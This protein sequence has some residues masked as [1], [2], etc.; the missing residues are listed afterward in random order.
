[1]N[2]VAGIQKEMKQNNIVSTYANELLLVGI[3]Y[4]TNE[5]ITG[6]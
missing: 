6:T 1:L 5:N 2:G 4:F 3:F